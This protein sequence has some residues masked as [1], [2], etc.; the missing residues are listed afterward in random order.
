MPK[1]TSPLNDL[2]VLDAELEDGTILVVEDGLRLKVKKDRKI[3]E[4]RYRK[5]GLYRSRQVGTHPDTP[6]EEVRM[7]L[8]HFFAEIEAQLAANPSTGS[9]HEP[10][11]GI[12]SRAK[13]TSDRSERFYLQTEAHCWEF[14]GKLLFTTGIKRE[15]SLAIF[16]MLA[17]PARPK[18]L[19]TAKWSDLDSWGCKLLHGQK[20][21]QR[22]TASQR[23]FE[24]TP[25]Q[26]FSWVS[27]TCAKYLA[28]LKIYTGNQEYIFPTLQEMPP[29]ERTLLLNSILEDIWVL[30]PVKISGLQYTFSA[31]AKAYSEFRPEF[32]DSLV[33]KKYKLAPLHGALYEFQSRSLLSWW[34]S[35]LERLVHMER[36]VSKHDFS[37]MNFEFKLATLTFP[38]I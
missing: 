2:R 9:P 24:F 18:D 22:R 38:I 26:R 4:A 3:F 8:R 36:Y 11:R 15:Y 34:G 20:R 16:L 29:Q 14:L 33:S 30:Y 6:I 35:N 23:S 21:H 28:D 32:I 25:T 1:K 17:L 13:S 5:N 10:E 19:L 27:P 31:L 7:N 12:K 37:S